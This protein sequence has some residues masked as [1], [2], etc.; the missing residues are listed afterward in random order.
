MDITTSRSSGQVCGVTSSFSPFAIGYT[1]PETFDFSGFFNPVSM[2]ADNIA[3]AGQAIPVK[4][5][6]HGD[7]GL[8]VIESARFVIEGTDSTPEGQSIPVTTAGASGLSYSAG[9]DTYTYVW[10]TNKAWS[11][12]TG[13]FELALTDGTVHSFHVTFKK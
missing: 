1:E 6:L 5:S 3:K 7:Q 13:R 12:K 2:T 10:K 11:L 9:S 4:F 8:E